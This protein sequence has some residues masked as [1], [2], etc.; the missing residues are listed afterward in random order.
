AAAE[1]NAAAAV[2]FPLPIGLH[3]LVVNL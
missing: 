1:D 2:A 3:R